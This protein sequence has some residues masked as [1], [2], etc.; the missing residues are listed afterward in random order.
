M[1][2]P[3][4]RQGHASALRRLIL[5]LILC[6]ILNCSALLPGQT[7]EQE[8][9][10]TP[11]QQLVEEVQTTGDASRGALVFYQPMLACRQCH[12][13]DETDSPLG[14]KLTDV[15]D[16]DLA[17]L[18][19]SLLKPSA[20]IRKG[21]ESVYLLTD[22]GSA[23]S[24]ILVS[25]D[26]EKVV[27][28]DA[29]QQGKQ[30]EV[31]IKSIEESTS[32]NLSLMPAGQVNQL[33]NRQQFL[34]LVRYLHEIT[35]GG[36]DRARLL[37]PPPS[38]YEL[39]ALPEYES[40]I[41]HAGM[42]RD[43]DTKAIARGEQIYQRVCVNCHGTVDKPGTLPTAL[44]F[45]EGRFKN[46]SDPH[47]MYRTM[48]HG[49]GM[50][51]AQTWMVPRQKYDV[52]HYIRERF[53][54]PHNDKQYAQVDGAYLQRL[55]AGDSRG[56]VPR[57]SQPW[58]TMNY[59]P[60]LINTYE[61]GKDA[62]NFAYKGIAMRLDA[63]PGG[64]ARGK[65]WMIF[66]HDTLRLA[67]AW[68]GSGF[69]DYNGIHFNGRH[70]IHPRVV[71]DVHFANPTMPGWG[72]PDS[73]SFEDNRLVGRDG[74]RYGPLDRQWAQYKG[75]YHY[76]RHAIVSYT[77]GDADV[78]EMPG[79]QEVD[80]SPVFT[81]SFQIGPRS[82]NMML[83]VAALP[84][85][86]HLPLQTRATG[87]TGLL[88]ATGEPDTPQAT[89]LDGSSFLQID[90]ASDLDMT[91]K[92]FT[93]AARIRTRE[94]G[95]IFAKTK[96]GDEWVPD[97][98]VLFI[99]GGRLCY[100]IGWV[101]VVTSKKRVADGKWHDV[102]LTWEADSG[103]ATLY[104]DG[105][106]SGTKTLRPE[107]AR[108]DHVAR[109]GMAAPDFPNPSRWRGRIEQVSFYQRKLS[110]DE[111]KTERPQPVASWNPDKIT[112]GVAKDTTNR[113]RDARLMGDAAPTANR[114]PIVV[115]A[116]APQ[117]SLDWNVDANGNVR[118]QLPA[119]DTPLRLTVFT[120]RVPEALTANQVASNLNFG[121]KPLALDG[122]L[123][124]GPPRWPEVLTQDAK[125]GE[126]EGPF[127]V[128]VLTRPEKNPWDCQVRLTG[129]DF[130]PGG[131]QAIVT[132][133]DGDVWHVDGV[134]NPANGLRWR[135]IASGLFQP[136]GVKYLQGQI[137]VTCRDQLVI[138][139]DLNGDMET[140][141]YECFN[142]VHQV[143][144]HFH[145]FAMGLQTDPEG[146]FYYAKS[147]RHA[148]TA[149][150]PHHG[151]LLKVSKDGKETSILA[152]GFRAA[153]GVCLNPDGTFI[154]T[155]QEGHWNPKNRINW[156]KP[157]K[158]YGNMYGY[159]G[160]TDSSDDAMEQPLCWI[161]N[162]FDRS[163][164]ELL[165]VQSEQWG[166]L[167]GSLLNLS[168]GYGKIYIVPHE[169]VNGQV[170]GGMCEL[171]LPKFPTGTIRGRFH[172]ENGQ[173]YTCG[174][175]AWAGSQQQPGGF[176]RVRYTGRPVYLPKELSAHTKGMTI[177]FTGELDPDVAKN[178]RRYA[179]KTWDLRRTKNYGSKHFNEKELDIKQVTLH[180][181][182][183]TVTIELP[184]IQP[185]WCMEIRYALEGVQGEPIRGV[186][187]NT[188]HALGDA[189]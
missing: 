151:T 137:F 178:P 81:R 105:V 73:G 152:T 188:I 95:T 37:E 147:A 132:A 120:G 19:E 108:D 179:V 22:D 133:W 38:L 168:Y 187:H 64:V 33:S 11:V 61:F 12:S 68:S 21:F 45:A 136:L 46:G 71:G 75:L 35:T 165:W 29:S 160:V 166:P 155:D 149:V 128:D 135:R 112:D 145:E 116:F 51:V 42:I 139:R 148:L 58:A 161:T 5:P 57:P 9:L 54:K 66:D 24:G 146:N 118:L 3:Q 10:S 34:D 70:G 106:A 32:R 16:A 62:S 180:A 123:K 154:V 4:H 85:Y 175:F 56:P 15:K 126:D 111:L 134:A 25:R 17:H 129:V 171:P 162:S 1:H 144:E 176:Y 72:H 90:R 86:S 140:D 88:M 80:G 92:D 97:G 109:I 122:F 114:L 183:R 98:K 150:V 157:G 74:R 173:L 115:G 23:V 48:T 177:R 113:G 141:Y 78:L 63:G 14:P 39:P 130:L 119:G 8:L 52:V 104:V 50:M 164:A 185:T 184:Q 26:D 77:V 87:V 55:P 89:R 163:P 67:G 65:Y 60:S 91:A 6:G 167:S 138:L 40:R 102:A 117:V 103:S 99:R 107:R 100:D 76:G 49:F 31:P 159:H 127:A 142:N 79:V 13:V 59:G 69:I 47:A 2:I 131:D 27:L 18:I 28:R 186:I 53:V 94:G 170:Q 169:H 84:E 121:E 182:G 83:Q 174:M 82:K 43:L 101:G 41:D 143:T 20:K 189:P 44:R 125:I 36:I 96:A 93:I 158:F 156:V 110:A 124:G 30:I 153:N 7:L 181:D 172:P